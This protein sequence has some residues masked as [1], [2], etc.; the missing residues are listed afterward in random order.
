MYLLIAGSDFCVMRFAYALHLRS[1]NLVPLSCLYVKPFDPVTEIVSHYCT[2]PPYYQI[3]LLK[4]SFWGSRFERLDDAFVFFISLIFL[5]PQ[6]ILIFI[7]RP[8]KI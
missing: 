7:K 6:K 4:S 5:S 1:Q 8:F 2:T 3:N